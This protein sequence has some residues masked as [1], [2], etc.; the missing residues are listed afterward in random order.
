MTPAL[1]WQSIPTEQE[2]A[3]ALP[4]HPQ[5]ACVFL[6]DDFSGS[7]NQPG[8]GYLKTCAA[9]A[10]NFI[11]AHTNPLQRDLYL[12]PTAAA[13]AL[14]QY[15][16]GALLWQNR[17]PVPQQPSP[18]KPWQIAP[19]P[20]PIGRVLIIGGGIAGAATAHALARRG[21]E[22]L[23]LEQEAQPA[24]AGSGNRQGLL[25]AKIS[26][27]PTL[28]TRLLLGSYGYSRRLL[29]HA[30]PNS[31]D[32]QACGVLHLN[33]NQ[34][35]TRR[36]RQLAEQSANRHLYRAADAAEAAAL[37]GIP[38]GGQSGLFWPQG[39]WLN[40]PAFAAA[41]LNNPYIRLLTRHR[42]T[43]LQRRG[44]EWLL[45]A[46][47][48][49]GRQT[50]S[51]SHIIFCCGAEQL[52]DILPE[53]LPLQFI[54]GQTSLADASP[55]SRRLSCALSA[56]GYISP[57]YLGQHCFGA[58]FVPNSSSSVLL[59]AEDN[60]NRAKLAQLSPELATALPHYHSG[61]AAVRADCYD[62]LPAVGALG[63]WAA[64]RLQYAK[65][66]HDKNYRLPAQPCPHLPGLFVNSGHGSRG[67]AT[68]PLCGEL[69]A[70]QM[71]GQPLPAEP[72]VA[73]ALAPNRLLIR[74][75]IHRQTVS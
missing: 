26:A 73:A 13:G 44:S 57:E 46:D 58:S 61:H 1:I 41:L 7:L 47:T 40:P 16:F 64:M 45:S 63:D 60:A 36:N 28:Q 14:Q 70:A 2:L 59:P 17:P 29:E 24:R 72:E 10:A 55:F 4:P 51:G 65:L 38:L 67:L 42:L 32:W 71:L 21:I 20:L 39:A 33:H 25:Y 68:A 6:S 54:R 53:A 35:E 9:P 30:L 11:P 18:A 19:P 31:P 15:G 12:L 69:V 62:H 37:A 43:G 22:S 75:I 56:D 52:T 27:H 74:Q 48:P 8:K 34:S 50:F 5:A 23:I 3:A 49:Q 66:A